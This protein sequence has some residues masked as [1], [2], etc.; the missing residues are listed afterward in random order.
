MA[1]HVYE[2]PTF[3]PL[4]Q[5]FRDFINQPLSSPLAVERIV[6]PGRGWESVISRR[7]AEERGCWAQF[8]FLAFGNWIARI[9]ET[10]L[11]PELAPKREPDSLTWAVAKRLPL[12][13]TDPEFRDVARYIY[14]T[15]KQLD[16][17]RLVELSRRIGQ[18]LD[19]YLL[20]RPEL[21]DSWERSRVWP[22]ANE[23]VPLAAR[24]QQRLWSH[25]TEQFRFRSV[26]AMANDVERLMNHRPRATD[27]R[28]SVWFAGGATGAQL[29]FLEA[30]GRHTEIALFSIV[31]ATEFWGDMQ[32]RRLLLK[33]R[34]QSDVSLR[35]FCRVEGI[36]FLHPLLASCGELSRQLQMLMAD[37]EH[38][39][40]RFED[41]SDRDH[42]SSPEE[43]TLLQCLQ[44][45]IRSAGEPAPR[46]WPSDDSLRIHSCHTPMR[47]VEVLRDQLRAAFEADSTLMPEDVAVF[48]PDLETY[49]PLV[50]AV[51]GADSAQNGGSIPFQISGRSPR[52]TRPIFESYFRLLATLQG[53]FAL[54]EIVD[55]LHVEAVGTKAGFDA[56]GVAEIAAWAADSGVRW[57]L[58]AE[59]RQAEGL[60]ATDLNTWSFGLDRLLL[61]YA[62]PP[63]GDSM[64]S[65]VV[66][67]DRA[68]GLSGA[69]LG[70]LW[71]FIE[72]LREWHEKLKTSRSLGAWREELAGLV[73]DFLD[74]GDDEGG[75]QRLLTAIDHLAELAETNEF[76]LP[77]PFAVAAREIEREV[78]ETAG[79]NPFRVGGV[80]FSDLSSLRSIP[81]RV[82]ALLGM[83]DGEFPRRERPMRFDL[84][85]QRPAIGDRTPR[86]EDRHLFLE[87]VLA[88]QDRLLITFVGQGIRDQKP[89]PPSVV[90]EELL[91]LLEHSDASDEHIR[92]VRESVFVTHPLQRFS[93]KYFDG[94]DD[95]LFSYE[96]SSL[97]AAI[98]LSQEKSVPRPFADQPLPPVE[99]DN[100]LELDALRLVLSEPWRLYLQRLHISLSGR[101]AETKDREPL[102]LDHLEEWHIGDRW[103]RERMSGASVE[104][105][106]R[107]FERSGFL[108]AGPLGEATVKRF[109]TTTE[110]IVGRAR[111][112]GFPEQPEPAPSAVR[113]TRFAN[114]KLKHALELWFE[115]VVLTVQSNRSLDRAVLVT[116]DRTFLY[117]PLSVE[118]A[119]VELLKWKHLADVAQCVPLPFIPDSIDPEILT[120]EIAFDDEEFVNKLM[121]N[122]HK[123]L[124]DEHR[125]FGLAFNEN[126]QAAFAGLDTLSLKCS[127]YPAFETHGD[128]SL[129]LHL[130]EELISLPG[131]YAVRTARD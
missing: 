59:Q 17:Q 126:L 39:A 99:T 70:R 64:V 51:F 119:Q 105:L 101:D 87:A 48:C 24:W 15:S 50:Q 62:M 4:W 5:R 114:M 8:E 117:E 73:L 27:E 98:S 58:D 69:T 91:A 66:A 29:R 122:A 53:R 63:G 32:S 36:E 104:Q 75:L 65:D 96:A 34:R 95:K 7:L 85:A 120:R 54:G 97:Q 111:R 113:R 100:E 86:L 26:R 78:D 1:I 74:P 80:V 28:I 67:L 38:E 116:R 77:L 107:R 123:Q 52:R 16:P 127:D 110:N 94:S 90:V 21:I 109:I 41:W 13:A 47:E 40:W 31:P 72:R 76:D 128:R 30:V 42:N 60:P 84:I 130:T 131:E 71:S 44:S 56:D 46:A 10:V 92:N 49:A 115:H 112:E 102:L 121:K 129:F 3:E 82:I 22:Y 106:K 83:N 81:Y 14:P 125:G 55:L 37:C 9:L 89:R 25:I 45:D 124:N 23:E 93:P 12:L 68:A 108:P 18:L 61:G 19:R 79:G 103:L 35:E 2:S 33:K 20:E 118:L 6:V 88:A 43:T 11:T 57:G